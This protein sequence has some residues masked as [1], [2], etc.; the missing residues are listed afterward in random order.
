VACNVTGVGSWDINCLTAK[1]EQPANQN[2]RSRVVRLRRLLV[3]VVVVARPK[4]PAGDAKKSTSLRTVIMI[5]RM[6]LGNQQDGLLRR[7]LVVLQL[8]QIPLILL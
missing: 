7:M 8:I 3:V 1:E 5:L 2:F 4:L 6:L